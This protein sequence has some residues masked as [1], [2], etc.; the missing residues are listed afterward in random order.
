MWLEP[1]RYHSPSAPSPLHY[2]SQTI[3]WHWN[4]W[5]VPYQ[6]NERH[7]VWAV[8]TSLITT[9][10]DFFVGRSLWI[11]LCDN[12]QKSYNLADR[13]GPLREKTDYSDKIFDFQFFAFSERQIFSRYFDSKFSL[14]WR[15]FAFQN[16]RMVN[17]VIKQNWYG[18]DVDVI[19]L[20]L[21]GKS[22]LLSKREHVTP[23]CLS[24]WTKQDEQFKHN[25]N[26]TNKWLHWFKSE[27]VIVRPPVFYI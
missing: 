14:F 8:L 13:Y 16:T 25:Y 19:N 18:N 4:L 20:V 12:C 5:P 10:V 17:M 11:G 3:T 24:S 6:T 27:N 21:A 15:L 26:F 23:I 2:L 22:I 7:T 1:D 9:F